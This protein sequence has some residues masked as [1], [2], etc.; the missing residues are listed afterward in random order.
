MHL[1]ALSADGKRRADT[2][3]LAV[4]VPAAWRN[5]ELAE[6]QAC[7]ETRFTGKVAPPAEDAR[8][9]R[10][11]SW[12]CRMAEASCSKRPTVG[13]MVGCQHPEILSNFMAELVIL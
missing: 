9:A 8:D 4:S 13:F 5:G 7:L 6:T 12:S 10:P 1:S 3:Q 11:A 2:R